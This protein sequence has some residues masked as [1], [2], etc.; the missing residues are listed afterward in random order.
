MTP[1]LE[2]CPRPSA[3]EASPS[4]TSSAKLKACA[5]NTSGTHTTFDLPTLLVDVPTLLIGVPT[6]LFDVPRLLFDVHTYT[7][8]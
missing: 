4:K 2:S 6:L 3:G 7:T 5:D 1:S 8:F